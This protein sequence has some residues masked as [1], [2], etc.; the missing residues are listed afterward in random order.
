LPDA[1]NLKYV[2]ANLSVQSGH[3]ARRRRSGARARGIGDHDHDV[4]D[5]VLGDGLGLE[6][7]PGT[8][9]WHGHRQLLRGSRSSS[10]RS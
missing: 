5:V 10:G 4:D 2:S 6:P 1:A 7:E 3:H 8:E 9:L